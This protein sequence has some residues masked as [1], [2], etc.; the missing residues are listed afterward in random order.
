MVPAA[1]AVAHFPAEQVASAL[2]AVAQLPQC[3][4]SVFTSTQTPLQL[5]RPTS[6]VS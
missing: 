6:H 5:V 4:G 1:H 3:V 2:Q